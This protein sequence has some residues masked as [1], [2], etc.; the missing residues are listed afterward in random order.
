[1]FN[2]VCFFQIFNSQARR[3]IQLITVKLSARL[4]KRGALSVYLISPAGKDIFS[5]RNG[6]YSSL[7]NVFFFKL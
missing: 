3:H 6:Y 1:M 4:K 7:F 5:Q 2:L